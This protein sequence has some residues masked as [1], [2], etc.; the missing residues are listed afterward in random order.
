MPRRVDALCLEL[1]DFQSFI[2]ELLESAF[3]PS[4]LRD[5]V[6]LSTVLE[7]VSVLVPVPVL[8]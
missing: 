2:E 4:N 5:S 7:P 6:S 8:H 1:L 3:Y